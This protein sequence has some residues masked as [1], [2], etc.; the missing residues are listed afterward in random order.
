[1]SSF[2]CPCKQEFSGAERDMVSFGLDNIGSIIQNPVAAI[3]NQNTS[4]ITD[5]INRLD[6]L[7]GLAGATQGTGA[8]T[9][10]NPTLNSLVND[11]TTTKT[12]LENQKTKVA[13]FKAE[14]DKFKD[15]QYLVNAIS[16]LSIFGDVKCALGVSGVDITAG[17]NVVND[18]GQFAMNYSFNA[19]VNIQEFLK[20]FENVSGDSSLG[21]IGQSVGE[22]RNR[23]S[24]ARDNL[25][26]ALS[27][28]QNMIS[29]TQST[30][31]NAE[32]FVQQYSSVNTLAG[33]ITEGV[34]DPCYKLGATING[35]LMNNQFVNLVSN[36]AVA[37]AGGG[38]SNR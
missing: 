37:A 30:I 28:L 22:I 15:P 27:G 21:Q 26:T 7:L 34:N 24:G 16:N 1:M 10:V 32:A 14:A 4:T 20:N 31:A 17:L 13:N 11:F 12:M 18:R 33:L 19:N 5:N 29:T 38:T 35:D 36:A 3:S 25:Q 6:R 23:L 8:G 9:L 2:P